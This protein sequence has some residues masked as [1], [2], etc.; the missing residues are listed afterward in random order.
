MTYTVKIEGCPPF[1]G[2]NAVEVEAL[3]KTAREW[4]GQK[5]DPNVDSGLRIDVQREE[6]ND[7]AN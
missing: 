5:P 3:V 1:R 2:C 4:R 7:V 6:T